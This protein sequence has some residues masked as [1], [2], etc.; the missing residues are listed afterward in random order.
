MKNLVCVLCITERC[1]LNCGYCY[2]ENSTRK[3]SWK[4]ARRAM[5]I[6]LS[7]QQVNPIIAFFGG[8]P[9]L[10]WSL[11]KKVV[12]YAQ[13]YKKNIQFDIATNMTLLNEEI[14]DYFKRFNFSPTLSFD[15]IKQANDKKRIFRNGRGSFE[16]IDNKLGL[17]RDFPHHFQ[18][19][20][21]L[22]PENIAYL[23][24]SVKYILEKELSAAR[25]NI[26]PAIHKEIRWRNRDVVLFGRELFKVAD[27]FVENYKKNRLLN[28]CCNEDLALQSHILNLHE[29]KDKDGEFCGAGRNILAVSAD[30]KL[31]PC[32]VLAG[33]AQ[34]EKQKYCVG[35][36]WDGITA[37]EALTPF[38]RNE[39]NPDMSC[40]VWNALINHDADKP[41]DIY[42]RFAH[43]WREASKYV[44][45]QLKG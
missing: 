22:T 15:G 18:I 24:D 27:L 11:I 10:E 29:N 20:I 33:L 4:T 7:Q 1:N 41:L 25:I 12:S 42:R 38:K 23:C 40:L 26:M 28:I 31:Y 35:D 19:R 44:V 34:K 9:L 6:V 2:V 21:T 32:Y 16:I 17:F 37:P 36:V 45:Q 3:M 39:H 8:E 43:L 5:D 14:V 30:G 13:K